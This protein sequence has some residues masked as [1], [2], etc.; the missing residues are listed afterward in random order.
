MFI[1]QLGLAIALLFGVLVSGKMRCPDNAYSRGKQLF[2]LVILLDASS[3]SMYLIGPILQDLKWFINE[4]LYEQD[5]KSNVHFQIALIRIGGQSTMLSPLSTDNDQLLKL[6][7]GLK[8]NADNREA[9]LEALRT[10]L[11]SHDF[12]AGCRTGSV[13]AC[14]RINW[15]D[16]A[17][18]MFMLITDEDSDLPFKPGHQSAGQPESSLCSNVYF[19]SRCVQS[20]WLYEPSFEPKV[21]RES[22]ST[23][24]TG[25]YTMQY[26]RSRGDQI[27]LN[28]AYQAEVKKTADWI[29]SYKAFLIGFVYPGTLQGLY[30]PKSQYDSS[31]PCFTPGDRPDNRTTAMLQF[32]DPT[33]NVYVIDKEKD[34]RVLDRAETLRRLRLVGLD[35]SVQALVLANSTSTDAD[36]NLYELGTVFDP[37]QDAFIRAYPAIMNETF[38]S[39]TGGCSLGN[40]PPEKYDPVSLD[41]PRDNGKGGGLTPGATVGVIVAVIGA[42]AAVSAGIAYYMRRAPRPTSIA[43]EPQRGASTIENVNPL[44]T[45][46]GLSQN[47]RLYQ[48]IASDSMI[49]SESTGSMSNLVH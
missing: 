41:P 8:L 42:F 45:D 37:R 9:S 29:V 12:V 46:S 2:D 35:K 44:F 38:R 11:E 39:L 15:R 24:P 43:F 7:D 19:S 34:L 47:N 26:C 49:R 3:D 1:G 36:V 17:K 20:D 4:T 48:N 16:G 33:L 18:K 5:D 31:S 30:G 25:G 14:K 22:S 32:G 23:N 40:R 21:F 6:L 13:D 28:D 27:S 10:S